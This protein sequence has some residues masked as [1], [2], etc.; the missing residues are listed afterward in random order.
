MQAL[1]IA[2]VL[3]CAQGQSP[4]L[5]P[6][7]SLKAMKPRPGFQVELMAA[8][9]L[10]QSPVAFNFGPDG[11]LWVVEMGDYP[12]GLDGKGQ[13]GGRVKIIEDSKGTGKF[14]KATLFLDGLHYPTAVLP[15]RK[16]AIVIAAPEIF[17]AEDTTGSG[18][19]NKKEVLFT[20]FIK[21]NPQHLA[22]SL[23]Y[24]LDNWIYC[25]N[26][27]SGG[28]VVSVKTGKRVSIRGRD[29]RIKP[30]TG[31]IELQSGQT[32]FGR[33]RDDWG[34]WFGNNNSQPMWHFVLD[35]HY[36]KRNPFLPSPDPRVMVPVISGNAPVYPVATILPRFNDFHT[37]GRFTSACSA[38]IYRDNLFGPAYVGNMFVSEPV[39]NLV[40]REIVKPKGFSFTSWR[41]DDEQQS[42]FLASAD[43]WFR[44]TTIQTG[45]DGALWVA[46]M[47]RFVIEHPQWIPKDW[48]AKLDLRAGEDKGRL[49]RVFPVASPPRALPRLDKMTVPELVGAL[50]NPSG[51]QRDLAQMLLVQKKDYKA[52]VHLE[53]LFRD[54]KNPLARLHALCAL[55]GMGELHRDYV[56]IALQDAHPGVRRHA[57]RL[58]EPHLKEWKYP[59]LRSLNLEN[60]DDAMV[61]L[62]LAYTLGQ[63]PDHKTAGLMLGDLALGES[64]DAYFLAAVFSSVNRDNF[65][66]FADRVVGAAGKLPGSLL[67]EKLVKLGASLPPPEIA[68]AAKDKKMGGIAL[69]LE[70]IGTPV[71][72]QFTANQLA[73]LG[74]YV[75]ALDQQNQSLLKLTQQ[76]SDQIGIAVQGLKPVFAEARIIAVNPQAPLEQR[77]LAARLLGRGLDE[78]EGDR[79]VLTSL[80]TPQTPAE[81]QVVAVATLGKV[82][83]I[84]SAKV[85]LAGWKGYGPAVRA[86]V[87]DT[88]LGRL[89]WVP[90]LLDVIDNKLILPSE[91][92]AIRRQR[93]LEHKTESIRVRAQRIFGAS[94]SVD[95]LKLVD[96]YRPALALK[97]DAGKG[98]ALFQKTCAACHQLGGLGQP[99]GPDLAAE[100]GKPGEVL[101]IA[102][103]DPNAAVETRYISYTATTKNGLIVS[104]LLA[105]ETGSSITLIAADGKKHVMARADLDELAST[106]KSVMPE[107]LDKDITVDQM[108]DLLAF[109]RQYAAV[110]KRKTFEGNTPALV[111]ANADGALTLLPS[112]CEIYGRTLILE[113][114][115]GNLGAWQSVDDR[116]VWIVEVPKAGKY[117]VWLD[118]A[119]DKANAGNSLVLEVAGKT[120]LTVKVG[121][122]GN[123]ETYRYAKIGEIVLEAGR[124]TLV[125]RAASTIQ[126]AL[127]DLKGITLV[128]NPKK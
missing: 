99:V 23:V 92:D 14:D 73:A 126:G 33:S 82:R 95:R 100:A 31:D 97:G 7:A 50:D 30:D 20:G 44:P 67:M 36:L 32:Q 96:S 29:F 57:V 24:G 89:E 25:A 94:T 45:P 35:E 87:L 79:K 6:E 76:G 93:L 37:A 91:V 62:Q 34:N 54:S 39:H 81:L 113:K 65:A 2:A 47:Y 111:T 85:M 11:K 13:P 15:W 40:H 5:T 56:A 71:D 120:A 117:A 38:I 21:G 55:D 124:Q 104:G 127:V 66:F 128:P 74:T 78:Q 10:V 52:V 18:K 16:G 115:H 3:L 58:M 53:K 103:L 88:L 59:S 61:R 28:E 114:Q 122:T 102:I 8:E 51:W 108:A 27:D 80:L 49:Y 22:N 72:G 98:S 70:A 106:G 83:T 69:L 90:P 43:N 1:S 4:A 105:S 68:A 121:S 48:Q 63:W 119:C 9:P 112:N 84:D 42:E 107:G 46:D 101:L 19:A 109:L 60:D 77:Q 12:Q 26:G 118:W 110:P 86:Q 17:Y 41:A 116:A 125:V 123:G 75:D 64:Q